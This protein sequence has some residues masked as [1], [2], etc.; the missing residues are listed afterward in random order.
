LLVDGILGCVC[1]SPAFRGQLA[2]FLV[3]AGLPEENDANVAGFG[4]F[5]SHLKRD[6]D[7]IAC[8]ELSVELDGFGDLRS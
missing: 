3:F 8:G 5:A 6:L 1:G 2:P 4:E 7:P